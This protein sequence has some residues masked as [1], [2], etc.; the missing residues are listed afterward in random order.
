MKDEGDCLYQA[1]GSWQSTSVAVS[2]A[3]SVVKKS[4]KTQGNQGGI[5]TPTLEEGSITNVINYREGVR[6]DVIKEIV[7]S[8]CLN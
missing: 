5:E 7:P 6:E 1:V 3:D 4:D 8:T 2:V